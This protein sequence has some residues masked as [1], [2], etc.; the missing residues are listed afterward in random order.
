MKSLI[1]LVAFA[2]IAA[3]SHAAD[4]PQW[5]GPDR[6]E[7]SKETGLLK[8]WPK[9]GPTKLWMS[10]DAGIGYSGFAVVGDTLY[11]MGAKDDKEFIF[12][13]DVNDG[14]LKWSVDVGPLLTNGWGDGPR[15]TPTVDGDLLYVLNGKGNLVCAQTSDGTIVWQKTMADLGGK[16]P[17]WG[18][19]ESVLID[20]E[21]AVCTPGG[22]QGSI[23]AFNKKTGELIWQSKDFTEDAQYSSIIVADH[24]GKHQYIQLMQKK[25]VGL[26]GDNGNVLWVS[27]WVGKTA[28]IPTPVFH[29]GCVYITSGYGAGC[30]L[31]KLD[32]EQAVDVYQNTNMKNHHGGVILVGDYIYGHSD[33]VGWVCQSFKTGELKWNEKNQLGK[34]CLTYADGMFYLL[35]ESRGEVALL[36]ASTEGYKEHG[37]FALDLQTTQRSPKGKIWTHP[38]VSNGKLFVR[39]Q[40]LLFCFDV[41]AK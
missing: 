4:W 14:R 39:D 20:G 3:A 11:S 12:A 8:E 22:K 21:K 17:N 31:V 28:V 9:E 29:D 7:V 37:R 18:Y 16:I 19:C 30:K 34:G 25:V 32:P 26:D 23:A 10:K 6:T 36:E 24:N 35:D 41:K 40:E 5:R 38:V 13:L 1:T 33:N 2:I 27:D 15:A